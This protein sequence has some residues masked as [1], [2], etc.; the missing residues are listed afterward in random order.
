MVRAIGMLTLTCFCVLAGARPPLAKDLPEAGRVKAVFD[1]DTILL[2]SG[3]RVRYLGI[4]APEVGHHG[5]DSECYGDQARAANSDW[6]LHRTVR[7]EYDRETR[8][9]YGRLLA[10]VW[11]ADGVCV[12]L[13]LLRDGYAWLFRPPI[14]FA[15]HGEFLETQR[16]ALRLHRGM[17]GACSYREESLYIGNRRSEIF[18]RPGCRSGKKTPRKHRI[19]WQSRWQALEQGYRPCRR[20]QP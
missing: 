20:C 13:A 16:E 2:E 14:G 6:V 5:Q 15:R 3:E 1:G 11:L 18:H 17:W 9:Q 12:N 19:Q 4:D 7:L 10:Y 8:D